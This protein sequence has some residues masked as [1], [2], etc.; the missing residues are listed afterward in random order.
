MVEES[1]ARLDPVGSPFPGEMA[2]GHAQL[3]EILHV[4][5]DAQGSRRHAQRVMEWVRDRV[6]DWVFA[7]MK[8]RAS[9]KLVRMSLFDEAESLLVEARAALLENFGENDAGARSARE[10]LTTIYRLQGREQDLRALGEL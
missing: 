3:A 1:L 8:V 7:N 10:L 2:V 9:H 4:A 6:G 5:G